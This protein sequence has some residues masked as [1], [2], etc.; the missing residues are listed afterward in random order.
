MSVADINTHRQQTVVLHAS[1]RN[2][3]LTL[4]DV[5]F[6]QVLMATANGGLSCRLHSIEITR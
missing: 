2:F 6:L 1:C 5:Q 3:S 4:S